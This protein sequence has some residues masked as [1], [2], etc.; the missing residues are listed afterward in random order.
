ME[1]INLILQV[2]R[3]F[4]CSALLF[5]KKNIFLR[6]TIMGMFQLYVKL[7]DISQIKCLRKVYAMA[8]A[9]VIIFFR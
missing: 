1:I 8:G 4:A 9:N 6:A 7:S 2:V 3:R 5:I